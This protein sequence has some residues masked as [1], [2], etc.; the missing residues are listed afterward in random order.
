MTL[1]LQPLDYARSYRAHVALLAKHIPPDVC[2]TA[3]GLPRAL[4]AALEYHGRWRVDARLDV[5]PGHEC[6]VWVKAGTISDPP[7]A[8]AG[9]QTIA[10]E[11][12]PTDKDEVTGVYRKPP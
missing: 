5:P 3:P 1:W 6:P 9:W 10:I 7:T 12:R 11:R 4:T 8:P 2:I